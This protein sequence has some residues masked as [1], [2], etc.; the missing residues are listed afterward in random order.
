[1]N[2]RRIKHFLKTYL[3]MILTI[4]LSMWIVNDGTIHFNV[5]FIFACFIGSF[6]GTLITLGITQLA[7][8][9]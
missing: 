7:K 1:M 2:N 6:V 4:S 8:P 5:K 9:K 3:I